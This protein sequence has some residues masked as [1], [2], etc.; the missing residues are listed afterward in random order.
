M[1]MQGVYASGQPIS[2]LRTD[3]GLLDT[4]SHT[5]D[6]V[7]AVRS[8]LVVALAG[9]VAAA[10]SVGRGWAAP[11]KKARARA[12][13]GGQDPRGRRGL[14][15]GA[16]VAMVAVA[17]TWP[18]AGHAAASQ[19][20]ALTLA[21]NLLH[22]LAMVVWLGGLAA[23]ALGLGM[24]EH[25]AVV[26]RSLPRFSRLALACVACLVVTGAYLA[27]VEVATP[28]A[29]ATTYGRVL[30]V[31]L[32]L[33]AGLL[34]LGE[35]ARRR[36]ARHGSSAIAASA[37]T[38]TITAGARDGGSQMPPAADDDARRLR[39]GLAGE[40]LVAAGVLGLTSA[41]VVIVPAR[42][43][44]VQPWSRTV[45]VDGSVVTVD[46]PSPRVVDTVARLL[47][48]TRDGRVVP[49]SKVSGSVA[50]EGGGPAPAPAP[51]PLTTEPGD[52]PGTQVG[53]SFAAAG[54]WV[55]RLSLTT[56]GGGATPVSFTVPVVARG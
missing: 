12:G 34:A 35:L 38:A 16:V 17:G 56:D 51:L 43:D 41:L 13:G 4:H 53:L 44:Y 25:R 27:W 19:Q 15:V 47:V 3:P 29:V 10:L 11:G 23:I 21:L 20:P 24:V 7:F 55:V 6:T 26:A 36:V 37:A 33:V 18:V 45:T 8:Y 28:A 22:T 9:T 40:T 42:A 1:L 50:L 49:V 39:V 52:R 14:L 48:T 54:Q 30:V 32:V 5:F 46:V 31:K 2:A